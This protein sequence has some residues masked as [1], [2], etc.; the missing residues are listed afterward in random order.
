MI[1][2]EADAKTKRCQESFGPP[3]SG[4]GSTLTLH[5]GGVAAMTTSPSHCIGT[6][7]MAWRWHDPST[8]QGPPNAMSSAPPD[9]WKGFCG[10]A[11]A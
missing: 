3:L 5:T 2:T 11:G 6:A 10:K 1:V 8:W 9:Q 7:C 4:D